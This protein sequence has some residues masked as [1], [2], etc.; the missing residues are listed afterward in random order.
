M[1]IDLYIET[2]TASAPYVPKAT[3]E[4]KD[5]AAGTPTFGQINL[6]GP[7]EE[8]TREVELTFTFKRRDTR[9]E[10]QIPWMQFTLFDFDH[11]RNDGDRGQEVNPTPAPAPPHPLRIAPTDP[12]SR[13]AWPESQC[14]TASGFEDYAVSSG[15]GV[16]SS[17]GG[18][19]VTT[20]VRR[21]SLTFENNI[22]TGARTCTQAASPHA[23]TPERR[24]C[25]ADPPRVAQGNGARWTGA[26]AATTR[27]T[28]KTSQTC[29]RQGP[30][31]SS[32]G[33]SRSSM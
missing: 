20:R 5:G 27:P 7:D 29:K 23:A 21:D 24:L 16:I 9:A 19:P 13:G 3:N 28:Q 17:G 26:S 22:N 31:R 33:A 14:A 30:S 12:R 11:N 32:S 1:V 18:A 15:V 10:V 8:G 2:T 6:K 4:L 25:A